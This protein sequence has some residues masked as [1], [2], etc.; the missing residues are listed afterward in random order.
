MET[1]TQLLT[2]SEVVA[3]RLAAIEERQRTAAIEAG[4]L[5]FAQAF[6]AHV[7]TR[8]GLWLDPDEIVTEVE[9]QSGV[10]FTWGMELAAPQSDD[11]KVEAAVKLSYSLKADSLRDPDY[12]PEWAGA[13]IIT[14]RLC[15]PGGVQYGAV[16]EVLRH[17]STD[18]IEAI[19][20]AITGQK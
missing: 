1:T 6:S 20:F 3:N 9:A 16:P 12:F 8:Y 11:A 19:T 14:T 17:I 2:I 10:H 15:S 13:R 7:A 4:K 18:L 5:E